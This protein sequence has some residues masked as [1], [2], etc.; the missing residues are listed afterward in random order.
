MDQPYGPHFSNADHHQVQGTPASC[1]S[2]SSKHPWEE[3]KEK[4]EAAAAAAKAAEPKP[5][6]K[7]LKAGEAARYYKAG[8]KKKRRNK[9]GWSAQHY[10][11]K[12]KWFCIRNAGGQGSMIG[13]PY[14]AGNEQSQKKAEQ[15]AKAE[16]E[17]LTAKDKLAAGKAAAD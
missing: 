7:G 15:D 10:K 6:K 5:K 9:L 12:H 17:R 8:D 4:K 16:A 14:T 11:G 13:F 1:S 3:A 2:S